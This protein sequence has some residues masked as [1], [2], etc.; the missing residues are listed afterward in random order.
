MNI[1]KIV[2]CESQSLVIS[3][4][5]QQ[6]LSME[7]ELSQMQQ[8]FLRLKQKVLKV[9]QLAEKYSVDQSSQNSVS[10]DL[11]SLLQRLLQILSSSSIKDQVSIQ[12]S[13]QS[14]NKA[15]NQYDLLQLILALKSHLE[16]LL[17][18]SAN[19]IVS[20]PAVIHQL[21]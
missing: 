19:S 7:P 8:K 11:E 16:N 18:S 3:K 6:F 17:S 14:S 15:N 4:I 10:L 1:F 13:T 5:Q 12:T 2:N 9:Y 20:N 21:T